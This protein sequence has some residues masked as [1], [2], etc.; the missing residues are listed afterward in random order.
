[1]KPKKTMIVGLA[2]L[3]VIGV[4][5]LYEAHAAKYFRRAVTINNVKVGGL[6][7]E[8][9]KQKVNQEQGKTYIFENGK[10]VR[11]HGGSAKLLSTADVQ[12]MFNQQR[13]RFFGSYQQHF[14]KY[15]EGAVA[16][17]KHLQQ[18][19]GRSTIFAING[20]RYTF[21]ADEMLNGT[22]YANGQYQVDNGA[23]TRRLTTINHQQMTLLKDY[24]VTTPTGR[25]A[26]KGNTYGWQLNVSQAAS[27]VAKALTEGDQHVNGKDY[28]KGVGFNPHGTG[29]GVTANDGLGKDYIA[30][31]LGQQHLWVYKDNKVV[32]SVDI[33]SGTN[34]GHD[35]TPTGVFYIGYKQSPSVLRGKNS[36]GTDYASKV[37]RWMPFT[38][39]G[40]GIHDASWRTRWGASEW[41]QNGSH[42]CLNVRP[43]QIDSIWNN[44]S[45]DEPI[46]IFN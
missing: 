10:V 38:E 23:I 9:A 25:V 45:K 40:C 28:L 4:L 8:Q 18:L 3:I 14:Q 32:A 24:Q 39:E 15:N 6:T 2:V 42:G 20:H 19:V 11:Q 22:T 41:Q 30:V 46:A 17:K 5:G 27:G 37:S 13:H 7:V 34:N 35:N 21:K 26:V 31:S 44:V 33:V 36:N 29:Y 43:S 16:A 12:Q 1:M